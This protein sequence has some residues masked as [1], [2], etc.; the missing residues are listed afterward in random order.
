ME[1]FVK[2]TYDSNRVIRPFRSRLALSLGHHSR[3][4]GGLALAIRGLVVV[5]L[6]HEVVDLA[7]LRSWDVRRRV[8]ALCDKLFEERIHLLLKVLSVPRTLHISF[9]FI[10]YI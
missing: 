4:C 5:D 10:S 1:L 7:A 3:L 6:A 9:C 8:I 2:I